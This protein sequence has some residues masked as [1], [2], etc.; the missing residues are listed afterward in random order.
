MRIP[1]VFIHYEDG[2]A[3]KKLAAES[4]SNV[5]MKITFENKK[6]TIVDMVLWLEASTWHIMQ[7]IDALTSW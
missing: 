7:I 5:V 2:E 4:N 3:L 1:S 6:T